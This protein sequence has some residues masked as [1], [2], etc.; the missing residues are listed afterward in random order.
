MDA[1]LRRDTAT[2]RGVSERFDDASVNLPAN[3]KPPVQK[4]V[5]S[6]VWAVYRDALATVVIW[7]VLVGL[8]FFALSRA[9]TRV[10]PTVAPL[11]RPPE[12]VTP[13]VSG[14]N[15]ADRSDGSP[16]RASYVGEVRHRS[17]EDVLRAP[18]EFAESQQHYRAG[19]APFRYRHDQC[20][21]L[22]STRRSPNELRRSAATAPAPEGT[23][24]DRLIEALERTEWNITRRAD[25]AIWVTFGRRRPSTVRRDVRPRDGR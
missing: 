3:S 10:R 21:R 8:A 12:F 18:Q 1:S 25:A 23:N 2:A 22:G 15:G 5:D 17:G 7:L 11:G 14:T 6:L 13:G 24:R 20:K 16:D 4:G 19:G 9:T